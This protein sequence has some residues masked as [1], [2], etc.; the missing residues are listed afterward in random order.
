MPLDISHN[1]NSF[2]SPSSPYGGAGL[3]LTN[4]AEL[5]QSHTALIQR[6]RLAA[7]ISN[8]RFAEIYLPV[9]EIYA[10]L[11]HLLPASRADYYTMPGGLLSKGLET[12]FIAL[13]S[14][15]AR[16]F[17]V[18]ESAE[19]RRTQEPRWRYAAF[20]AG[21]FHH[22]GWVSTGLSAVNEQGRA[23]NPLIHPLWTWLEQRKCKAYFLNIYPTE[24][25]GNCELSSLI[26]QKY[27][28]HVSLEF[29]AQDGPDIVVNLLRSL[30]GT[31]GAKDQDTLLQVMRQAEQAVIERERRQRIGG[32]QAGGITVEVYLVD[33]MRELL[34]TKWKVNERSGAVYITE[35][36]LFLNWDLAAEDIKQF[37]RDSKT[38]GIPSNPETLAESLNRA[39]MINPYAQTHSLYWPIVIGHETGDERIDALQL[40]YP[41][42]LLSRDSPPPLKVLVEGEMVVDTQN[43]PMESSEPLPPTV[44]SSQSP[45]QTHSQK[46]SKP[47]AQPVESGPH[48]DEASRWLT[49]RGQSGAILLALAFDL[50]A[51][52]RR[53]GE[54][55]FWT[56]QGIALRFPESLHDYGVEEPVIA[57]EMFVNGWVVPDPKK[58]MA[59]VQSVTIHD[60][61]AVRVLLLN[62]E[63]GDRLQAIAGCN[64]CMTTPSPG[65]A[66]TGAQ[67]DEEAPMPA[68]FF[69]S[70]MNAWQADTLMMDLA[71]SKAAVIA[72]YPEIFHWFAEA[73]GMAFNEATSVLTQRE[74]TIPDAGF[75]WHTSAGRKYVWFR[76][77]N[78][79]ALHKKLRKGKVDA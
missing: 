73:S 26:V 75:I 33:A 62:K 54:D 16:I 70:L 60:G 72:P 76:K 51:G 53:A 49:Q 9:I 42:M 44:T 71:A 55:V 27:I 19:R 58:P 13:Q 48:S 22:C 79:E 10:N 28:P 6:I 39:G 77:A 30:S 25:A 46:T 64:L 35:R 21:L 37:L 31:L 78:C 66:E 4:P 43:I 3:P 61:S 20:I 12:G 69:A 11:V 15:D 41:E 2:Q 40:A 63:I 32:A 29:I 45:T 68:R 18:R 34:R 59:R 47:A 8:E 36:G 52:K 57:N 7:G 50:K 74:F 14:A 5:L 56:E 1:G 17:T 23:W 67:S 24:S 38:P 65:K